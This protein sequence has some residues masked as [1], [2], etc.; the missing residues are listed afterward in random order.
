MFSTILR[1]MLGSSEKPV[2]LETPR[3]IDRV[4]SRDA[5]KGEATENGEV[6]EEEIMER[7]EDIEKSDYLLRQIDEFREK[8]AQ[9][10][11]LL[12]TRENK[13]RELQFIVDE[14]QREADDLSA[15]V[16]RSV[17]RIMDRVDI[18][19]DRRFD[20]MERGLDRR[21]QN[22][23]AGTENTEELK[24]MIRGIK[25]PEVDT[26]ELKEMIREIKAPEVDT[27]ELKEMI[28]G[29]KIPE[30]DTTEI[31]EMIQGIKLPEVDTG[32]ITEELKAP[33]EDFKKSID[34]V[35]APL[36]EVTKEVGGMK[37][38]IL[39]KIH[40]EGVQ[41]FRNTR[42]LLDEQGQKIEGLGEVKAEVKSLKTSLKIC[43][44]FGI[45]NFV[46]LIVYVLYDLGVFSFT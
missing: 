8:A 29:I 44:W 28:Q 39:E 32:K 22:L 27:T 2:R 34:E 21:L 46:V 40:T 4:G 3:I 36:T 43:L 5:L 10:Q 30:A 16:T 25:A 9:L 13:A 14:K 19:I 45:I 38:E 24:E 12:Q 18:R 42:D 31:K 15:G 20:E 37:G 7:Y 35:K 17:E 41:V 33:I 11:D 23:P 26:T 1:T 6:Q